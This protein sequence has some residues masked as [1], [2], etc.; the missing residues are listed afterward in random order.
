VHVILRGDTSPI[1]PLRIY[2]SS[3]RKASQKL[4][5]PIHQV[6]TK[7]LSFLPKLVK[8]LVARLKSLVFPALKSLSNLNKEVWHD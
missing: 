1:A 6:R 8:L 2:A 3:L 7:T 5:L 4:G